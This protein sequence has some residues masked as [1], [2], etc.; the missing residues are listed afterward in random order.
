MVNALVILT[1]SLIINLIGLRPWLTSRG[2]DYQSLLVMC[3]IFGFVGSFISLQM[4]R[5]S[6]K[7]A[8]GVQ[9]IDPNNPG[10]SEEMR[11]VQ[12]IRRLCDQAGLD[13]LPE[14]GIYRS[15]E[16]NAFATGPS[17]RRA[18]LAI[19][20]G[21]LGVMDSRAVEGVIGHEITHIVNGDMVTMTLV[22][23]VVNTFVMFLSYVLA[24]A[25]E[26]ALERDREGRERGGGLGFFSRYLLIN[27]LETV[28]FL[29]AS[30]VIYAFSR[31]REY[32]ADAGSA[33]ITGSQTMIH[34]LEQLRDA[35][36]VEDRRAPQLSAF[37]IN[38]HGHGLIALLYSSHP[39][40]EKR[41]EALKRGT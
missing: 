8:M 11:L 24:F 32:R 34:A 1:V 35:T 41:I 14:I 31:W 19:S 5:W 13:T 4:S 40:I 29:L 22:Q 21:L 2:I 7:M 25:I 10:G 17:R 3:A 37:K 27:V 38:G 28:L 15:P 16:V 9:V 33:H 36:Q 18:L 23:G 20:S 6:A 39:S 26:N 30:P 12:M